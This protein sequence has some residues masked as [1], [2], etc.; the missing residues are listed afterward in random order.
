MPN[1]AKKE[2]KII[3]LTANTEGNLKEICNYSKQPQ[4]QTV[5]KAGKADCDINTNY[6]RLK[7]SQE[8]KIDQIPSEMLTAPD[9]TSSMTLKDFCSG[10]WEKEIFSQ[11]WEHWSVIRGPQ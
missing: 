6:K 10:A 2:K 11:R 8:M 1:K 5:M 4:C 7:N 9:S 3:K